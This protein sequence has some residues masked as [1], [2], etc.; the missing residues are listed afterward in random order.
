MFRFI[1]NKD[2]IALFDTILDQ[3][4][5]LTLEEFLV[6]IP[7]YQLPSKDIIER[8]YNRYDDLR[9]DHSLINKLGEIYSQDEWEHG[10]YLESI[11]SKIV[12]DKASNQDQLL[13]LI[14]A[15]I[16]QR[17]SFNS[18][19]TPL[20]VKVITELNNNN[21]LQVLL[22]KGS[23]RYFV[24][25]LVYTVLLPNEDLA[26]EYLKRTLHTNEGEKSRVSQVEIDK[27]IQVISNVIK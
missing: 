19:Y 4:V 16:E 26:I 13:D 21:L 8:R 25:M 27:I 23:T 17:Q 15:Q 6:Y 18:E 12:S 7:N 5:V 20:G 24:G 9:K 10:S 3:G 2:G 1:H 22:D 11:F 14:K